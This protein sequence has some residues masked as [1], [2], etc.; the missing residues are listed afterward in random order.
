M[1]GP[2]AQF[3]GIGNKAALTDG[4]LQLMAASDP[5]GK[6]RAKRISAD[7]RIDGAFNYFSEDIITTNG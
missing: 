1:T 6:A 7:G 4:R 2:R 5:V 3:L